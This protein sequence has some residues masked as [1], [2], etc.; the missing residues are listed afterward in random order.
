MANTSLIE[1]VSIITGALRTLL[2]T[3]IV[4]GLGIGGWYGYTT[5]NA[6]EIEARQAAQALA[7]ATLLKLEHPMVAKRVVAG[8]SEQGLGGRGAAHP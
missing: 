1:K 2:A 4:G 5:Y 7:Q 8:A 3:A 6:T